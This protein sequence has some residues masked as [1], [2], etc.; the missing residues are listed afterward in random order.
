M[1]K[2][3][4]VAAEDVSPRK[5]G[6]PRALGERNRRAPKTPTAMASKQLRRVRREHEQQA[7]D[8]PTQGILGVRTEQVNTPQRSKVRATER[9]P[10]SLRVVGRSDRLSVQF[11]PTRRPIR[12]SHPRLSR[13]SPNR[14]STHACIITTIR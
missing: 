8:S 14:L 2:A 12:P 13:D 11:L 4:A 1:S 7:V 5:D 10:S 3:A 6:S 9:L